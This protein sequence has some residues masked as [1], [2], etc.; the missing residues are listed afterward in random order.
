MQVYDHFLTK[1]KFKIEETEVPGI[2]K[3]TPIPNNLSKYY[4]SPKYLSHKE[5]Y[6]ILGFIYRII[7]GVNLY[8]KYRIINHL[9]NKPGELLD[10]GCGKG[11]FIK[12]LQKKHWICLG[13]EPNTN[14]K[15]SLTLR[16]ITQVDINSENLSKHFDIITLWHVLEHINT[17]E[18]IIKDLI[19]CLKPKGYLIIAIPN[20]ESLDAKY[21]KQYWAAYDVPRHI[22]HFNQNGLIQLLKDLPITYVKSYGQWFD[23]YYVSILSEKYK[24]SRFGLIRALIIATASNILAIFTKQHSSKIYIFQNLK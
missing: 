10:Y 14:V 21:Y 7:Q 13:Y 24:K 11:D 18:A 17:P 23:S 16:N 5:T 19:R 22:W 9:K 3:T 8:H 20:Y 4:N 2:K 15:E 6:D 12:H 1:E